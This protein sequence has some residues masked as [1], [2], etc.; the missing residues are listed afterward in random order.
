MGLIRKLLIFASA[1]GLIIQAHGPVE[2]HK[3]VQIAYKSQNVTE[4]S[5]DEVANN[6]KSAH[7]EAHGVIGR[8]CRQDVVM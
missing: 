5:H 1:N 6:K 3:A 7:L 8:L 4:L 2:H